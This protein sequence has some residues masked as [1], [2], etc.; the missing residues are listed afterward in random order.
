MLSVDEEPCELFVVTL[1]SPHETRNKTAAP[2]MIFLFE[3]EQI[4]FIFYRLFPV[5][6]FDLKSC[7]E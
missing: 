3:L 6:V 1:T 7:P 2:I 5:V 4:I